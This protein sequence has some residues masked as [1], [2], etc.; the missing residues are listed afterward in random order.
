VYAAQEHAVSDTDISQLLNDWP[1][2][3]GRIHAR[4]IAGRDGRTKLQVRI[5]LGI[6][7][8]ELEGRP[9]GLKPQG[10]DS[11]LAMHKARLREYVEHNGG[12]AGFILTSDECRALRE[13]AVQFY[14]R[15]VALLS[16]GEFPGVISDTN[17]NLELLD[18]CREFGQSEHDRG[19]LEQFRPYVIMMRARAEAEL[20]VAQRKP[21]DALVAIDRAIL[22]I[23]HV[24]ED[25][26]LGDQFDTSSEV[27]LLRSMRDALVPKLPM[28]Q[29]VEL[30]ERL[31]AALAAENY[32]LAAILRD[33]LRMMRE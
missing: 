1:F 7:Q 3:P 12:P 29:R 16:L 11:L 30:Q 8:L 24:Y 15:Y 2:E 17:H 32:E 6:L 5:D 26:G 19:V 13:E 14:H 10:F 28:S 23:Q 20:A 4:R 9:D 22:A 27:Q 33:E 21:K 25:A 18:L 31:Q